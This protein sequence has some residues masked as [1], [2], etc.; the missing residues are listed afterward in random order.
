MFHVDLMIERVLRPQFVWVPVIAFRLFSLSLQRSPTRLTVC[1]P[2]AR[3]HLPSLREEQT[4]VLATRY[5]ETQER[6]HFRG[7][8]MT[9]RTLCHVAVFYISE[10]ENN[11]PTCQMFI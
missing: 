10:D 7:V 3:V 8:A 5:L 11:K 1:A 9:G 4:V 2:S 6:K